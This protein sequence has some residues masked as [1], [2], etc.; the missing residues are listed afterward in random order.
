MYTYVESIG[1]NISRE[2]S[3]GIGMKLPH[4]TWS[5]TSMMGGVGGMGGTRRSSR[6]GEGG[7]GGDAAMI[8]GDPG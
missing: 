7:R 8:D 3:S 5:G 4:R 1:G 6:E 2:E